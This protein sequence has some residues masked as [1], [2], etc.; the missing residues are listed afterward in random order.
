M[1]LLLHRY[2]D[3]N[4]VLGLPLETGLALIT[5]AIEAERE[6]RIHL[7]WAVQ[8]PLMSIS[9]TV[10]SF[11]EY[12]DRVTGAN[13]DLRPTSEILAEL[14]EVEKSFGP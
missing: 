9:G 10:L 6:E 11:S 5:R 7:Q 3:L 8:L 13:I 4:Y 1:D 14:E 12:R 2:H